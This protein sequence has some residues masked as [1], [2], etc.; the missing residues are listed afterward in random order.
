ML[1][2]D[3]LKFIKLINIFWPEKGSVSSLSILSLS[4]KIL[5]CY[6]LHKGP[7]SPCERTDLRMAIVADHLGLSWTGKKQTLNANQ[8]V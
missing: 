8:R 6:T 1:K 7:Q 4:S 5:T 2:A 3:F